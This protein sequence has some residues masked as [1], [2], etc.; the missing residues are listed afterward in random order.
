MLRQPGT[1]AGLAVTFGYFWVTGWLHYFFFGRIIDQCATA[2]AVGGTVAVAW[3]LLAM[4]GLWAAERALVDRMGRLIG[5]AAIAV[6]L[7]AFS[8]F[9]I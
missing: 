5:A 3:L 7:L 2:I 1:V 6:G 8:Q 9:G 4:S